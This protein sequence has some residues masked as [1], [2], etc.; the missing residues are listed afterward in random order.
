MNVTK[1]LKALG[2]GVREEL[3][4][5]APTKLRDAIVGAEQAINEIEE[6]AGEDEK[7]AGAKELVRDLGAG[8]RDAKKAQRAKIAYALHLLDAQGKGG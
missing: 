4:A 8:Y 1:V 6:E 5:L 7:L 3:E 2:T